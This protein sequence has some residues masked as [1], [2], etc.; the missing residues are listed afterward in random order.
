MEDNGILIAGYDNWCS[1]DRPVTE[2]SNRTGSFSQHTYISHSTQLYII[3]GCSMCL[4]IQTMHSLYVG[5]VC[6]YTEIMHPLDVGAICTYTETMHPLY[7]GA[8]YIIVVYSS[9]HYVRV[10]HRN[11]GN[12]RNMG[13]IRTIG[14][15]HSNAF[16][17]SRCHMRSSLMSTMIYG[18]P[19]H[20][21]ATVKL[22]IQS[23]HGLIMYACSFDMSA[24]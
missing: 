19:F 6:T 3:V 2:M 21:N 17:S 22:I 23:M 14:T 13:T 5:A 8:V 24:A 12:N 20:M 7:A 4:H 18:Y 9:I 11:D 15:M 10:Q 1:Q 16:T